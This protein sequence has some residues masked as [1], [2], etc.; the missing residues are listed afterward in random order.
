MA[1]RISRGLLENLWNFHGG[2]QEKHIL[3][4][5]L[6]RMLLLFFLEFHAAWV[7]CTS[8]KIPEGVFKKTRL[9]PLY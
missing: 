6:G 1:C 5:F 7:K 3:A 4:E 8:L 2:D 9:Q